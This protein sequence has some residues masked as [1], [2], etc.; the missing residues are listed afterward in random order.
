MQDW[1]VERL[2]DICFVVK[3]KDL[4]YQVLRIV[5]YFILLIVFNASS[6]ISSYLEVIYFI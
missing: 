5:S 2:L 4:N 3:E 6:R 1:H